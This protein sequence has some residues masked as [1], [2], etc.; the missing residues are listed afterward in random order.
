[1]LPPVAIIGAGRV[2]TAIGALLHQQG[3]PIRGVVRR[4][5]AR[6]EEAVRLIGAGTPTIDP[7]EGAM[8]AEIIF[9]TVPDALVAEMATVLGAGRSFTKKDLLVHTSG[10]LPAEVLAAPG[11]RDA[12]RLSLHPIQTIADPHNG[13]D[14]L[15]GS[16]FGLEGEP[17]AISK[18]KELVAAI[19]GI[20]LVIAPGQKPLYHA[21]SCV[22]SNYLVALIEVG[23]ELYQLAGIPRDEALAAAAPL[24]QGTLDNVFRLGVPAALTGPIERGDFGTVEGHAQAL[25]RVDTTEQRE[26]LDKVYRLLGAQTLRIAAQKHGGLSPAHREIQELLLR[27]E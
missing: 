23:L 19:G 21:A 8:G 15:R 7:V 4:S 14:K 27:K 24:L 3:Y 10:A 5:M 11:A 12:L 17:E 9:I 20:P 16:A 13:A 1:M 2:G 18:G 25:E 26:R 6:A 22:M